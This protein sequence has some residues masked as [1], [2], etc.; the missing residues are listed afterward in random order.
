MNAVLISKNMKTI[1]RFTLIAVC[2][3]VIP[4]LSQ[5][6]A[7]IQLDSLTLEFW[8]EYDRPETL[9]IYRGLNDPRAIQALE[10]ELEK[11]KNDESE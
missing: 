5:A 8:P 10:G 9:V 3:L 7:A 6:Q 2:L 11:L 1:L 4:F